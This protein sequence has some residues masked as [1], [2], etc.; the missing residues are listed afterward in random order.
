MKKA[1]HSTEGSDTAVSLVHAQLMLDRE[2]NEQAVATLSR[3]EKQLPE[4]PQVLKMLKQAYVGVGDWDNLRRLLPR[5]ERHNLMTDEERVLLERNAYMASLRDASG[6]YRRLDEVRQLWDEM[7]D[8][9]RNEKM[10]LIHGIPLKHF[11]FL[12]DT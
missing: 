10:T 2:Q 11:G 9:L 6:D 8:T 1:H 12:S 3:L 4:H 7:P 5:L